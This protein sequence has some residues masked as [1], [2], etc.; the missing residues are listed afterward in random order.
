MK[1]LTGSKLH[2]LAEADAKRLA[3]QTRIDEAWMTDDE[4]DVKAMQ[5]AIIKEEPPPRVAI[6]QT[7]R[8]ADVRPAEEDI[9]FAIADAVN[10]VD[11]AKDALRVAAGALER[12]QRKYGFASARRV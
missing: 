4:T 9:R 10:A 1:H 7:P 6:G 11:D 12:V 3:E 5:L 8:V 2:Y